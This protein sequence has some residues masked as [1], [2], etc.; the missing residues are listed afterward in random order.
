MPV[1]VTAEAPPLAIAGPVQ[2]LAAARTPV[3]QT[4]YITRAGEKYHQASCRYLARSSIPMALDQA[5]RRYS[6]CSVCDPPVFRGSPSTS[7]PASAP[8]AVAPATPRA[9]ASQVARQQCAATTKKGTRCLRLASAGSSFCWRHV[10]FACSVL[11]HDQLHV[12]PFALLHVDLYSCLSESQDSPTRIRPSRTR[13][14][15]ARQS[16]NGQR[17]RSPVVASLAA[18][19]VAVCSAL[20]W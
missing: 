12:R 1:T 6:P 3:V 17:V 2:P 7:P 11:L 4:V 19:D 9:P 16:F 14:A 5:A 20:A 18:E 10:R 13:V 15:G 8:V